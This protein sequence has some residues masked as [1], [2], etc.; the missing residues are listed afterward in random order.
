M[1]ET[2]RLLAVILFCRPSNYVQNDVKKL[3]I[4]PIKDV[5]ELLKKF[6]KLTFFFVSLPV[7]FR[8]AY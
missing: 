6:E 7:F 2:R 1:S 8:V 4:D 3:E 5:F